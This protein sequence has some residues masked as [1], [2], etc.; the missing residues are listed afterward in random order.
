MNHGYELTDGAFELGAEELQ[1]YEC[2]MRQRYAAV[3]E[4]EGLGN[5]YPA[6]Q[7]SSLMSLF[8]HAPFI[9]Q[10]FSLHQL[11]LAVDECTD[12]DVRAVQR[13]LCF[14]RGMALLVR[15]AI[16]ILTSEIPAEY[17]PARADILRPILRAGG[18]LILADLSLRRNGFAHA[19]DYLLPVALRKFQQEFTEEVECELVKTS[20][21][22]PG[23]IETYAPM[24]V[25]IFLQELQQGTAN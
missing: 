10:Y 24:I 13:D 14:L 5:A 15:K 4:V 2:V 8:N 9:K 25:N 20:K 18:L 16:T 19:I 12:S 21:I 7:D 17:R 3:L 6:R 11:K 22:I 1:E 23:V